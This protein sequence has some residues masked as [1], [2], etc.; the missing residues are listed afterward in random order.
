MATSIDERIKKS[1]ATTAMVPFDQTVH[2]RLAARMNPKGRVY[3]FAFSGAPLS[4]YLAWARQ[5]TET[6]RPSAF[7]FVIIG[8]DFDESIMNYAYKPGRYQYVPAREWEWSRNDYAP[9]PLRDVINSSRLL[10]YL[11]NVG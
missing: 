6:Y 5:A 8:N 1:V 10:R 9:S 4:Q 3:S 7:V 11:G 2:G